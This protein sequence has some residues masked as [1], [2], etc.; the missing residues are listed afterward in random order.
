MC[1]S[2]QSHCVDLAVNIISINVSLFKDP[3]LMNLGV[4]SLIAMGSKFTSQRSLGRDLALSLSPVVQSSC[5]RRLLSTEL[6]KFYCLFCVES[7]K[8]NYLVY[9]GYHKNI[10]F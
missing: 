8:R 6:K 10:P 3:G 9:L 4:D 7:I 1:N 5:E 2:R